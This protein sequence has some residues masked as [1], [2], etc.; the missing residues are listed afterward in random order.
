MGS[1]ERKLRR[2][3]LKKDLKEKEEKLYK[4]SLTAYERAIKVA[5]A[6]QKEEM[7]NRVY[8]EML[9]SFKNQK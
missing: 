8:D 5:I 3:K 7:A 9:E 2:N 1:F 4:I 6:E